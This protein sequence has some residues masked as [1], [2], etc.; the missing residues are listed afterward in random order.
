MKRMMKRSAISAILML[1]AGTASAHITY[2][3]RNFGTFQGGGV[4]ENTTIAV[5]NI[6]SDFGWAAATDENYGDSHRTRAFRFQLGNAGI[7]T[8]SVQ[9]NSVGF[10]PAYSIYS[11]LSH[12][13]PN[14]SAH[15][16]A[17]LSLDYL[18][19]LSG[20]P[21]MG[22]LFALGD[23][24]IGND[25]VYNVANNPLSGILIP[26]SLRAFDYIGNAADGTSANFGS[27]PGINGDGSLADGYV[28]ATF[29][30]PAG[31]YSIF[32]GGSNLAGEGPPPIDTGV[33]ANYGADVTLTVIPEPSGLALSALTALG[34]ALRRRR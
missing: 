25:P 24:S 22:A 32:V 12:V 13:S 31:D 23:W 11:G 34:L 6:S 27:A 4:Y 33:Y 18:D 1:G 16:T 3:G 2:S 9:S 14:A 21:K 17:Q 26:A 19:T 29:N 5:A 10:L 30:L 15:D 8:L 7:V 28:T 20:P